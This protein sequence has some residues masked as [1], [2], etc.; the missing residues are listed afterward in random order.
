MRTFAL[1]IATLLLLGACTDDP[2]PIEPKPSEPRPTS[3]SPPAQVERD[4]PEGAAAFVGHYVDLLNYAAST[5]EVDPLKALSSPGCDGCQRYIDLYS[6]IY[7]AG[8]NFKGGE[9][10][11]SDFELEVRKQSTDVFVRIRAEKGRVRPSASTSARSEQ[12][13][14]GDVVFEVD[15][16]AKDRKVLRFERLEP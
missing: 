14:D 13:F 12:A 11:A 3:P 15:S 10:T 5:G 8:G 7:A 6:G 2:E 16:R 4:T 1:A 9:W